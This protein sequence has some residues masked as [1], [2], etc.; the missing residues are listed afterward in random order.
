MERIPKA[1]NAM[2]ERMS[3]AN[4]IFLL[5]GRYPFSAKPIN[6]SDPTHVTGHF[7]LVSTALDIS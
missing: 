5:Q 2:T 7:S 3:K 4:S 1:I 6:K